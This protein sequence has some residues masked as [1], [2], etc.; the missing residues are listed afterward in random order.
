[1]EIKKITHWHEAIDFLEKARSENKIRRDT[2]AKNLE[3]GKSSVTKFFY[4]EQT[5]RLDRVFKYSDAIGAN[6]YLNSKHLE[7]DSELIDRLKKVCKE[8]YKVSQFA[9]RIKINE[10]QLR[11]FFNK[12]Y[13]PNLEL[14]LT[15][16]KGLGLYLKMK[17]K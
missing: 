13:S 2:I 3:V 4:K 12:R 6:I 8:K 5:P 1:M 11:A 7:T 10:E 15:I 14:L 16:C 9:Q 17:N